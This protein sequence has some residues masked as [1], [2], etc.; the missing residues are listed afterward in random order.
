MKTIVFYNRKG[1][2]G[3]TSITV[4]V[5][6]VLSE[7]FK[8]KVLVLDIDSQ[9]NTTSYLSYINGIPDK[10]LLEYIETKDK[11]II[12][13]V[14]FDH[15]KGPKE[16]KISLLPGSK[17]MDQVEFEDS[18]EL[19]KVLAEL[20][21]D[22]DYCLID[23]PPGNTDAVWCALCAS[24]YIIVPALADMDSLTGYDDL[25]DIVQ[26]VKRTTENIDLKILGVLFNQVEM[27]HS[28]DRQFIEMYKSD[29]EGNIFKNYIRRSSDVGKA[30]AFGRPVIDY[31]PYANVTVDFVRLTKEIMQKTS[32]Q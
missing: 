14:M 20:D 7:K 8:K 19:W 1:G 29:Y 25:M 5:A 27:H 6:G 22:Y 12:Q 26:K 13:N 15:K 32:V 18:R 30:R 31:S 2:V 28:L 10:T 17:Q 24:K 16:T 11:S 23:S 9:I 3:K 21:S 4:N